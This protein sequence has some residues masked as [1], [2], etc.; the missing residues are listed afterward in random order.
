MR[1]KNVFYIG[2]NSRPFQ[3]ISTR[4]SVVDLIGKIHKL[5]NVLKKFDILVVRI[6]K[7]GTIASSKLCYH[8]IQYLPNSKKYKIKYK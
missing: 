6:T 2:K 8:S 4:Y 3:N 5:R 7:S 1:I